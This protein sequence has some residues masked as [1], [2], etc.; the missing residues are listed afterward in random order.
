MLKYS[1][2]EAFPLW[3]TQPELFNNCSLL[4]S[5]EE[6]K[7]ILINGIVNSINSTPTLRLY[8]ENGTTRQEDLQLSV[9]YEQDDISTIAGLGIRKDAGKGRTLFDGGNISSTRYRAFVNSSYKPNATVTLNIGAL[10][11]KEESRSEASSLRGAINFHLTQN[12]TLRTGLS[13]SERLPSLY[14]SYGETTYYYNG[15]DNEI[16]NAV[17]RPNSS[18]KPEVVNSKEIGVLYDFQNIKANLDLRIFNEK[19][20]KGIETYRLN[21]SIPQVDGSKTVRTEQNISSWT[22]QGSEVQFRIQPID[23]LWFV[24]NYTYINNTKDGS[25]MARVLSEETS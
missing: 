3:S 11:E 15:F 6:K 4:P 7:C 13:R 2:Y 18:L 21:S 14:E 1:N 22:N 10:H 25:T 20:T 5:R 8:E 23:N 9:I 24:L 17:R 19:I 12:L 16:F